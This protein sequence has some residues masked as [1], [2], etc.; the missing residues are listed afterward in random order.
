MRLQRKR[1]KGPVCPHEFIWAS[2]G[3]REFVRASCSNLARFARAPT[4]KITFEARTK[5]LDDQ[6]EKWKP[7]QNL[8]IWSKLC[9]R[10]SRHSKAAKRDT[11]CRHPCIGQILAYSE[12]T[13]CGQ[14]M[15][16]RPWK[17]AE[18]AS[19]NIVLNFWG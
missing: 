8:Q 2:M 5:E 13:G 1:I 6:S 11:C 16:Y 3:R 4:N 17:F 12:S 19:A 9:W 7:G 18:R 15:N 10:T 14:S